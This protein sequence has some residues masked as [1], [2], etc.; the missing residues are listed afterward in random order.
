MHRIRIHYYIY[1]VL[2]SYVNQ[3]N[4]FNAMSFKS[5][6]ITVLLVL[7]LSDKKVNT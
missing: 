5:I 7:G 6:I 3:T 1:S 2:F 4:L